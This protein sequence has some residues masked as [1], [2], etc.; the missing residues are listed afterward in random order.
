MAR[1]GKRDCV[2]EGICMISRQVPPGDKELPTPAVKAKTLLWNN[3]QHNGPTD[4]REV[5]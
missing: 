4:Y 5:L 1:S 3:D 2:F